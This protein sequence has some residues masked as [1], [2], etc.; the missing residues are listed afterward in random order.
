MSRKPWELHP[1]YHDSGNDTI[2]LIGP[3]L[4]GLTGDERSGHS[5]PI[6]YTAVPGK[7][8]AVPTQEEECMRVMAEMGLF[9]RMQSE[10]IEAVR[11]YVRNIPTKLRNRDRTRFWVTPLGDVKRVHFDLLD[12]VRERNM[13]CPPAL[14]CNWKWLKPDK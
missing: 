7:P 12:F 14:N 2:I 3:T 9:E 8:V 1:D 11:E 13:T 5:W 6:W 10:E 4:A